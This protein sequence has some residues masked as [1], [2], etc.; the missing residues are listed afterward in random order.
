MEAVET[1]EPVSETPQKEDPTATTTTTSS[2]QPAS[3]AE[4]SKKEETAP[5][6][7]EGE[8]VSFTIVFKKQTF[9][10]EFGL[11]RTIGDLRQEVAK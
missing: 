9:N 7:D 6:K 3:S 5:S 1:K 8:K 10:V 4:E 11:D 2:E